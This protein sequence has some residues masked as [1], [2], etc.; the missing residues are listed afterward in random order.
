MLGKR[1]VLETQIERWRE[2][3]KAENKLFIE[4]W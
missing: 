3:S 2:L 1:V 4:C